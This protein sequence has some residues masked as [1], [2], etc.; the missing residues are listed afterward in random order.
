MYFNSVW[1]EAT[2]Y[3]QIIPSQK[4]PDMKKSTLLKNGFSKTISIL[5]LFAIIFASSCKKD[6][7]KNPGGGNNT[8]SFKVDGVAQS[9]TNV[10]GSNDG[11]SYIQVRGSQ[12]SDTTANE[13]DFYFWTDGPI[14]EGDTYHVGDVVYS[15]KY[16]DAA[17]VVYSVTDG[18]I[19][20]SEETTS[21]VRGTFT[22]TVKNGST[23]KTI[24]DGSFDLNL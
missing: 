24:T 21:R 20:F 7:T 11:S 22:A 13:L 10:T 23:T 12:T 14:N 4:I 3:Q 18:A 8:I 19:T 6:N 17:G 15:V 16:R 2:L 5:L 1:F 9:F